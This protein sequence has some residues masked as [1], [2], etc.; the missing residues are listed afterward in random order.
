MK[1]KTKIIML[2]FFGVIWA[3]ENPTIMR[4]GY[5]KVLKGKDKVFQKNV[6]SHVKKWH[7]EGQWN[8]FGW[9]VETGPRTG[10]Y[11][12]GTF[13]H[14]W[15]DFDDRVT[16]KEHD[17]DWD[18]ITNAYIDHD[19]EYGGSTFWSLLPD[20]SYNSKSSTKIAVTFYYCESNAYQAMLGILGKLKQA[21]EKAKVDVSYNVYQ[22]ETGGP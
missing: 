3:Q 22:K 5:D 14:Y 19:N 10:Q 21:N 1:L 2:L 17:S 7:G 16:T 20:I 6:S 4:G 11:F 8:Q 18:R 9:K 15:K 13:G 12:I